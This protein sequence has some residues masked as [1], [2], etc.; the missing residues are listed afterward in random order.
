MSLPSWTSVE[1]LVRA[2]MSDESELALTE[3]ER[4]DPRIRR[5]AGRS[6]K[7]SAV[8]GPAD[9]ASRTWSYR[10]GRKYEW[11]TLVISA[12]FGN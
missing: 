6:P 4:Q 12:L 1:K 2:C 5:S 8:L 10:Q 3:L 9:P 11:G 7:S